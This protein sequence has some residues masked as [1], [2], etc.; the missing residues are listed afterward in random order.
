ML[1]A[2]GESLL[3]VGPTGVGKT[4]L[5]LQVVGAL[6]GVLP[7]VL[8]YPVLPAKR[9]LYL[10]MD[11]PR[12]IQRAMR[13]LF[14]AQHR[15]VLDERV[16]V[17]KG[18]L[19]GNLVRSP[20]LL[21]EV[22]AEHGCD[23]VVVDSAKDLGVKLSDEEGGITANRAVQFC[24]AVDID[25][26]LLHHQRKSV[27]GHKP[28]KLED[29]YGSTWLTAGAGSVV[30]LWGDAGSELVEL[31]HLKQ[32]AET[33]GPLTIEHDHHAG[34]SKVTRGVGRAGVPDDAGHRGASIAEAAQAHHG[35]PQTSGKGK[36]K[37]TE[38]KLRSLVKSGQATSTTQ[39][40]V[41]STVRFYVK[42]QVK[43]RV[44]GAASP[45]NKTAGQSVA[46]RGHAPWTG[47]SGGSVDNPVDSP[48]DTSRRET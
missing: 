43:A 21:A 39:A 12:Q 38:R 10:A 25:V 47:V 26:L 33:I 40:Q 35:A 17:W 16:L 29:V 8:G 22:A 30:L 23:V 7:D 20:W 5:A 13:R 32:P 2:Q 48:V 19:P 1:W 31:S 9:V 27:E 41:G 24:N 4:T 34:T 46:P 11:R 44:H 36:W 6:I 3:L 45:K 37:Q 14:G 28:T 18:P 15:S 42:P